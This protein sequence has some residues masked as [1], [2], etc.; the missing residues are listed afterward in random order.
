MHLGAP[1]D[2]S[3]PFGSGMFSSVTF[4]SEAGNIAAPGFA[5]SVSEQVESMH[6][7]HVTSLPPHPRH[8]S[9]RARMAAAG[10]NSENMNV[11]GG[12]P[13]SAHNNYQ[14]TADVFE[15]EAFAQIGDDFQMLGG[16]VA[17]SVHRL[18]VH[19]SDSSHEQPL[20]F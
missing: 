1:L 12:F 14:H 10:F 13:P 7:P 3:N 17:H 19:T 11:G 18:P 6:A 4:Y 9:E 15:A 2:A 16:A 20:S 5:R 8:P